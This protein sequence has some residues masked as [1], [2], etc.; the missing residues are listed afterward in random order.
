MFQLWL[1]I[2][3]YPHPKAFTVKENH[4]DPADS[5]PFL[6]QTDKRADILEE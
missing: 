2:K 1:Y 5:E 4:I 6:T 3:R